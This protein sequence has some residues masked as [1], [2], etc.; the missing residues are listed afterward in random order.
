M[1]SPLRSKSDFVRY[2][3]CT[4]CGKLFKASADNK[5]AEI[6]IL[7]TIREFWKPGICETCKKEKEE[8]SGRR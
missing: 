4:E 2:G 6:T 1:T 8:Y 5:E 7:D 3:V